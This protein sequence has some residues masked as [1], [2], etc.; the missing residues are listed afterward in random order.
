MRSNKI[1]LLLLG[2]LTGCGASTMNT[3][4]ISMLPTLQPDDRVVVDTHPYRDRPPERGDIVVFN[5]TATLQKYGFQS[6]FVKRIVG[7]PGEKIAIAKGKVYVNGQV[8]PEPYLGKEVQTDL[9]PCKIRQPF[10][11]VPQTVPPQTYLV[12]GDNRSNSFDGRCWGVVPQSDL[13]S[14]MTLIYWPLNR[15]GSSL[16]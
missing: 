6:V 8:L 13:V 5:P 3:Y 7:L 16:K 10:L 14:K 2:T 1:L 4:Y 15:F 12:L 9:K 11:E